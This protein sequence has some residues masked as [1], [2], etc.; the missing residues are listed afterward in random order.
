MYT[1]GGTGNTNG[2]DTNEPTPVLAMGEVKFG[3]GGFEGGDGSGGGS[4]VSSCALKSLSD[5][6]SSNSTTTGQ[7]CGCQNERSRELNS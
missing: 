5:H 4:G 1:G 3:G 6:C 7:R 2:V